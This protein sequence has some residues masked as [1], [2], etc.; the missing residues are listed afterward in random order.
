[1]LTGAGMDHYGRRHLVRHGVLAGRE[2]DGAGKAG[3]GPKARYIRS[4]L[5]RRPPS[6]DP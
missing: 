2:A 6:I 1:M 3:G 4:M 5:V